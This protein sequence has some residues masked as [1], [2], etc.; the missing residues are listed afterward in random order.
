[1]RRQIYNQQ[2][3]AGAGTFSFTTAGPYNLALANFLTGNPFQVSRQLQLFPRY[4]RSWE[5]SFFAQD[6][7]R[8]SSR[9]C[10]S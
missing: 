3:P 8:V 2:S 9:F 1:M 6:D 7:W 4:L 10:L 5:P